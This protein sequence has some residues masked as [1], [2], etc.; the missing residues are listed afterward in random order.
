MMNG[1][2]KGHDSDENKDWF[3]DSK[4]TE[5]QLLSIEQN[6]LLKKVNSIFKRKSLFTENSIL[7][8]LG[9]LSYIESSLKT[10]QAMIILDNIS[11]NDGLKE[12][13]LKRLS[14]LLF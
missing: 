3:W 5:L 4:L 11:T 1:F 2:N 12:K 10:I 14:I 6:F 9:K 13:K 7:T 8:T